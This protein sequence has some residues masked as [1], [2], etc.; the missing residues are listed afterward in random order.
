MLVMLEKSSPKLTQ[1]HPLPAVLRGFH[2]VT[3]VLLVIMFALAWTFDWIGPSTISATLVDLHRS[4]GILLVVVVVMRLL[5]R[6]THRLDP[7]PGGTPSWEHL[8]A[9]AVQAALYA[10]LLA[11]PFLGW[12]AS[13]LSGDTISAFGLT[14]PDVFSMDEDRSDWLFE[15]HGTLGW[16][17]LGLVGLHVAGAL[18][19][20]FIKR[21]GV[22]NRMRLW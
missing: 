14:L 16:I 17:L 15:L 2:W 22:L 3:V 4:F 1:I 8:L 12:V 21:D 10:C 18:R 11:M 9:S 7:L 6:A 13:A 20:H 19:H 5:W